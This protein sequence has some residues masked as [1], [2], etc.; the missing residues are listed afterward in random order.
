[1]KGLKTEQSQPAKLKGLTQAHFTQ[2]SKL[3]REFPEVWLTC[4]VNNTETPFQ[5]R[6]ITAGQ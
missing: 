3:V 5:K 6:V 2:A 4:F 1:M